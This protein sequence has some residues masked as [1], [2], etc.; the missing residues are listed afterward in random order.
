MP[1]PQSAMMKQFA[2][3]KLMSMNIK[4]PDKWQKPQGEAG[5]Q[6]DNA[7]KPEEKMTSPAVPPL[8]QAQ[9]MNKY[10]TDVQ[11]MLTAKFGSFMDGVCD[12]ICSAWSSWQT[13]A[14]LV[15][16]LINGPVAALGQVVG[17]PWTPLIL[18]SAPKASPMEMKYSSVIANVI[19]TAWL[20]YTATIKVPGLPWYPAFA[21]CALPVSPP[22]PNTPCPVAALTQ[23]KVSLAPALMKQQMVGMLGDPQAMYHQQLFE[24]ICD[25]FDKCFTIWQTS[26]Q[27]TNVIGFGPV[28]TCIPPVM[29]PGPVVGGLGTM[30]PGGFA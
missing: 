6:Y 18:A 9:T 5:D 2:R 29:P 26:T 4:V 30:T 22:M 16:V 11:K 28:P 20:S 19:G 7:F 14:T 13:A 21:L 10:H 1:A 17:P 24:S 25:A 12:A 15:G 27:V 8:F 3:A 23:V